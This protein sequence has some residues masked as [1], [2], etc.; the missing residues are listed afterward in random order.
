MILVVAVPPNAAI[1]AASAIVDTI[2]IELN[3]SADSVMPIA[4]MKATAVLLDIGMSLV[5]DA[6]VLLIEFLI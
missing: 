3:V 4:T 6:Y 5:I 1:A 2:D